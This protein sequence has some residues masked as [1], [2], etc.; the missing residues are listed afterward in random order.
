MVR[1]FLD[2]E[3]QARYT[4][5]QFEAIRSI[6]QL[7]KDKKANFIVVCGD[8]FENNM[9]DRK[10]VLKTLE[11]LRTIPVSIYLLPGNHDP[12]DSSSVFT[13]SDFLK[14]KPANVTVLSDDVPLSVDPLIELVPAPWTSKRPYCDPLIKVCSQL[15][16]KE[17][18]VR[19]AV[20]HGAVDTL[21][22]QHQDPSTIQIKAL[23]SLIEQGRIHYV[24]LGDKHSTTKVAERIWYSGS[25][26]ATDYD[27]INS[28]NVLLVDIDERRCQVEECKLGTWRYIEKKFVIPGDQDIDQVEQYL[29]SLTGKDRTI[30]KLG[31]KGSVSIG[32]KSKLD[33]L[34]ET[35]RDLFAAI[36]VWKQETDITI[37]PSEDDLRRLNLNGFAK[38]TLERL[39]TLTKEGGPKA[40]AAKEAMTLL[41]RL[42]RGVA[43]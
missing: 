18:T 41:Y 32:G 28:G 31:L 5:D 7:A 27:E 35:H 13:C 40:E 38:S 22:P 34:I 30:L 24:A 33:L 12:M 39:M 21:S 6:G 37:E 9:V 11:A 16:K 19:I 29:D 20:G 10:T 2:A 26:L 17:G 43:E 15:D 23:S 14:N 1:H 8:V 25:P 3:S 4:Q 42:S 36:E